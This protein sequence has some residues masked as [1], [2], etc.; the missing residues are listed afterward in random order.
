MGRLKIL[1][2]V[3]AYNEEKTILKVIKSLEKHTDVLIIDDHSED[4]TQKIVKK[5]KSLVIRNRKNLGYEKS[6]EKGIFA[7]MKLNYDYAITFD[8]DG[9]HHSSDIKKFLNLFKSGYDL[10]LGNRSLVTRSSEKIAKF[11]FFTKWSIKDPFCGFKG[12]KLKIIKKY[13]FFERY[14]S[15]GV[16]L[17]LLLLNRGVKFKNV[18]IKTTK[19]KGK[20]K[21]GNKLIGNYKIFRSI[22]L[23]FYYN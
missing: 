8:A 9:Q 5:C 21:F 22:I 15:V 12:Y 10:V 20:S 4:K 23:S 16:D 19:R 6:I 1:T 13:K 11:L 3:P 14:K 2:I 18:D 17:S 7:A